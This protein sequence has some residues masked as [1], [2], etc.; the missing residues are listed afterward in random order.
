LAI[1]KLQSAKRY[2]SGDKAV[3]G[4]GKASGKMVSRKMS[5]PI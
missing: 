5:M 1:G 3:S 2:K 4:R